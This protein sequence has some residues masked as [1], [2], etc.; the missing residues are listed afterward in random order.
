MSTTILYVNM[1]RYTFGF[2]RTNITWGSYSPSLS[3]SK[4][5]SSASSAMI[6]A[7]LETP[8]TPSSGT[9]TGTGTGPGPGPVRKPGGSAGKRMELPER[10]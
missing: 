10:R 9:G 6:R 7:S 3:D 8:G 1:V 4:P 2:R 5:E